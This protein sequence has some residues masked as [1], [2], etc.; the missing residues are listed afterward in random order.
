MLGKM[1]DLIEGL[2]NEDQRRKLQNSW[3][4]FIL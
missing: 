2:I 1:D 3:S 4:F